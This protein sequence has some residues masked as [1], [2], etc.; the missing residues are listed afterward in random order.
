M[1]CRRSIP[2]LWPESGN[3]DEPADLLPSRDLQPMRQIVDPKPEVVAD[4]SND[5][6]RRCARQIAFGQFEDDCGAPTDPV[7]VEVFGDHVLRL[8]RQLS[9][10]NKHRSSS[11][12]SRR[13]A[14]ILNLTSTVPS[15]SSFRTA[16][17]FMSCSGNPADLATLLSLLVL[18]VE[19][20]IHHLH[21]ADPPQLAGGREVALQNSPGVVSLQRRNRGYRNRSCTG[22]ILS[23][24]GN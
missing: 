1:V 19:E 9:L 11:S 3:V 18:P 6:G 8:V 17:S 21:D 4:G 22:I 20:G 7:L 14:L 23:G 16:I 10:G 13:R 5:E 12:R 2:D 15:C 24:S